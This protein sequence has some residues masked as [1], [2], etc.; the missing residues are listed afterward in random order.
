MAKKKPTKPAATEPANKT[1]VTVRCPRFDSFRV[2]QVAGMFDLTMPAEIVEQFAVEIPTRE[3]PWQIGCIVGPS[4][5]GKSSVAREAFGQD[6]YGGREWPADRAVIDCFELPDDSPDKMRSIR[7]ITGML[8]AVG[9]SSPPSWVKPYAVLSNGEKFRCDLARSILEAGTP[10]LVVFDEFTSVVDRTVAQV[11][12]Q[13]SRSPDA[14]PALRRGDLP[15]RCCRVAAARLGAR[16]AEPVAG[17]G[18]ASATR[19]HSRNL[20]RRIGERLA[21]V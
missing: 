20:S 16:H 12:S 3:E 15:L 9:F 8:T 11:G 18:A 13:Q 10:G 14:R 5:S 4:G 1:T 6:L 21:P 19:D 2:Q 17:K 7:D